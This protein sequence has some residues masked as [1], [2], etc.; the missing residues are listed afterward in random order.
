MSSYLVGYNHCSLL[1]P[2]SADLW[3]MAEQLC[4]VLF[5]LTVIAISGFLCS[6]NTRSIGDKALFQTTVLDLIYID[7]VI[8]IFCLTASQRHPNLLR[9]R[10]TV[11]DFHRRP[12]FRRLDAAALGRRRHL[13]RPQH[14][15]HRDRGHLDDRRK[16]LEAA[17]DSQELLRRRNSAHGL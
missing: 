10:V 8:H 3:V 16:L 15:L 13:L 12:D 1:P 6:F 5:L 14:L 4:T 7:C 2:I 11:L 9:H 17:V